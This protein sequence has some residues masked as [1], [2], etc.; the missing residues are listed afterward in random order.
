MDR[1]TRSIV[2]LTRT[3]DAHEGIDAFVNKRKP[4]FKGG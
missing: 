3:A 1:E 2:D 4:D